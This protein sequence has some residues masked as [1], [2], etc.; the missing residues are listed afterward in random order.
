MKI[1]DLL[2]MDYAPVYRYPSTHNKTICWSVD[3]IERI[4]HH[5]SLCSDE[6]ELLVMVARRIRDERD[7]RISSSILTAMEIIAGKVQGTT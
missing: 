4:V 5:P 3:Q 7:Y 6:N 2:P 1:Q